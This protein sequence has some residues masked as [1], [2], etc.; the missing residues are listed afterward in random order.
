MSA[1]DPATLEPIVAS[2]L[3]S[4]GIVGTQVI[5]QSG[6]SGRQLRA[7][8]SLAS[9]LADYIYLCRRAMSAKGIQPPD[10][11]T[12][13]ATYLDPTDDADDDAALL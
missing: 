7:A 4:M 2:L 6:K 9:G 8:R 1:V 11:P 3:A 10:Y 13:I 12:R 5:R